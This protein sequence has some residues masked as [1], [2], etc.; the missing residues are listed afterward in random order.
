MEDK[1]GISTK[2]IMFDEV[3][4]KFGSKT[5]FILTSYKGVSA[6]DIDKLRKKLKNVDS[7]YFVVKNSIARRAFEELN[8]KDLNQFLK[9]EVGI[10]LVGNIIEAS[11]AFTDFSKAHSSFKLNGAYIDGKIKDAA[12]IKELAALPPREMLLAMILSQMKSPITGFVGV[13]KSL[14]RNLVYAINEIKNKKS[15]G[16]EK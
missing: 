14:L 15:E 8:L 1:F 12:R 16:G 9:G 6:G 7:A 13:L 11:K 4:N 2:K 3:K 5:S 10:G